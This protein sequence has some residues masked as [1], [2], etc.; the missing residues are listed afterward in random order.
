M[1]FSNKCTEKVTY[2]LLL[3]FYLLFL[4]LLINYIG[5]KLFSENDLD[6]LRVPI[7]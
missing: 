1:M 6:I 4:D 3:Y 5:I 7:I 2:N